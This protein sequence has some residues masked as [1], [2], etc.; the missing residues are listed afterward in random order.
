VELGIAGWIVLAAAV[1]AGAAVQAAT[2][3]GFAIVAAPV[4]LAVLD[5]TTAM[6]L[7]VALHVIQCAAL[8]PRIWADVP[9]THFARLAL[10]ATIG[11]PAGLVL[12][13]A[14]DVRHLKLAVGIV[15]LIVAGLLA[16]RRLHPGP[17]AR[18]R[19]DP[20]S[21]PHP[22]FALPATGACSGALTSVLVMPGPPLMAYLLRRPLPH[23]EARALS[24]A[25]FAGCYVAVLAAHTATGA[26]SGAWHTI[27][28]LAPPVLLGTYAGLAMSRRLTDRYFVPVLNVLLL[29]AGLGALLSAM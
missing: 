11:C 5:S 1:A 21:G 3:F 28:G 9:W 14:L 15:I 6:P 26:L 16:W 8:V 27:L 12:F 22:R 29:L 20:G 17:A 19:S 13:H 18:V 24:I 4:F 25:F 2:G 10:G 7:L 23:T